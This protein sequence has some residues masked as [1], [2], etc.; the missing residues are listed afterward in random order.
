MKT[1]ELK[2]ISQSLIDT[3]EE[4][5]KASIDLYKK[6]LKIEIK[7]DKSAELDEDVVGINDT[8]YGFVSYPNPTADVLNVQAEEAG[9]NKLQLLDLNGK[10]ILHTEFTENTQLNLYE[11]NAGIYILKVTNHYGAIRTERIVKN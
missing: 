1:S 8:T 7:E 5:G 11:L 6:G 4:A 10:V 9:I 3:F 2:T